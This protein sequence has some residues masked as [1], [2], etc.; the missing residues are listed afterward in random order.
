[1]DPGVLSNQTSFVF[2]FGHNIAGYSA[3]ATQGLPAGATLV[4]R[5]AELVNSDT[6]EVDNTYCGDPCVCGGDG[7]NCANQVC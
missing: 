4:L 3:L 5:H 7:G 1:M 6:G 2:D